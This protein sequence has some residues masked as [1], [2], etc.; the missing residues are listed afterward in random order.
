MVGEKGTEQR[1]VASDLHNLSS[2]MLPLS[3]RE[4]ATDRGWGWV[5]RGGGWGRKLY[6]HKRPLAAVFTVTQ[7]ATQ[8][9]V[10]N[11]QL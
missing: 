11:N 3:N 8:M 10:L 7:K 6:K 1:D 9:P 5:G 4:R 2:D